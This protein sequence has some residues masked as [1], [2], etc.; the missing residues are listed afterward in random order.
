MVV[1]TQRRSSRKRNRR[2][3]IFEFLAAADK[4]R[5]RRTGGTRL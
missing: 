5:V 1:E 2:I 3:G 4:P